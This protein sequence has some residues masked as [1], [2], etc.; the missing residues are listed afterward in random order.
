MP[1]DKIHTNQND[2]MLLVIIIAILMGYA[3]YENNRKNNQNFS[4]NSQ[5][6]NQPASKGTV[7]IEYH[8]QE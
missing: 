7:A 6:V 4:I 2:L 5:K 1:K 3:Y 8:I